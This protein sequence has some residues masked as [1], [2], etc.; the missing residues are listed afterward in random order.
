[1]AM[2]ILSVTCRYTMGFRFFLKDL[3]YKTRFF[4]IL[5]HFITKGTTLSCH[6]GLTG[7]ANLLF[8]TRKTEGPRGYAHYMGSS[9]KA[10]WLTFLSS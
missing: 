10:E 5:A 7:T 8:T 4:I 6:K 3:F 1:M 9:A 2:S